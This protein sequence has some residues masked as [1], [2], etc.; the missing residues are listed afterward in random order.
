MNNNIILST[1]QLLELKQVISETVR[2]E[3]INYSGTLKK[4]EP[5]ELLTRKE[6]ATLLRVSLPTLHEWSKSG[7]IKFNRIGTRV[8]YKKEDVLAALKESVTFKHKWGR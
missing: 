2:E 7:L 4:E 8:L 3:L 1:I 5:A 6:A